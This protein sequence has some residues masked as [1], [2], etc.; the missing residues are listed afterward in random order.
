MPPPL[1]PPPGNR[2]VANGGGPSSG[3]PP[4]IK[5]GLSPRQQRQQQ[6]QYDDWEEAEYGAE[7]LWG[8]HWWR[9]PEGLLVLWLLTA[10]LVALLAMGA[11]GGA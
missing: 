11:A 9:R 1:P 10:M 6:Q 5:L 3:R 2:A 7:S 4:H 8:L